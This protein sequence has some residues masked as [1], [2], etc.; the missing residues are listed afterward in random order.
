MFEIRVSQSILHFIT[1]SAIYITELF[2]VDTN[3]GLEECRVHNAEN[4]TMFYQMLAAILQALL[5]GT[6]A[7][8]NI[9]SPLLSSPFFSF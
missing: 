7:G 6:Y 2:K 8:C 1:A 9:C 3:R 4:K 5:I